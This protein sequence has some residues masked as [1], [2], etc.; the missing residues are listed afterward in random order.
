MRILIISQYHPPEMGA[1]ATRWSD[2]ARLLASRGYQIQV[3]SEVPNYPS[4]VISHEYAPGNRFNL[5]RAG[6]QVPYNLL[7]VPVWANPRQNTF[8]RMGFFFSFMC[9][10]IY[11]ALKLPRFDLVITTSPPLFVGLVG[12]VLKRIKRNRVILDIRDLWPESAVILGELKNPLPI[13]I[14]R[15]LERLVYHHV[16][17]LLL[18]VP[19]FT[20]HLERFKFPP[21]TRMLPLMN[22]VDRGFYD[23]VGCIPR[24]EQSSP[25]TVVYAGNFGLAQNLE[26]F[27]QAA[28]ILI[29]KPIRFLLV[30]DG[31]R[32]ENLLEKAQHRGLNQVEFRKPVSRSELAKI[33]RQADVGLV[34]LMDSPL[35]LHAIP[36]KLLEFMACELPSIVSIRGEVEALISQS[37]GG[38]CIEPEDATALAEKILE[39][40]ENPTLRLEM[41]QRGREYVGGNLIKQ[42]LLKQAL[43]II[44]KEA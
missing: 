33:L 14:G 41:G 16:N 7:R 20:E 2:Y 37:G 24:T 15:W 3:I 32:R 9:S 35:F 22:G 6:G 40:Y 21:G 10:A 11:A 29:D 1:A 4:G 18:A 23:Q 30:G 31:T 5:V 44:E 13:R 17:H 19:G 36:S 38:L 27:L 43:T 28:E 39:L 34:P 26:V 42:D 8:Q 12:V 25:F